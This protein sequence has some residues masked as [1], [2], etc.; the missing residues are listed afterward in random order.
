MSLQALTTAR[1]D[2]LLAELN[3]DPR[4]KPWDVYPRPQLVREGWINLNGTWDYAVSDGPEP[5]RYDRR[6]LVPFPPESSLSG[7][8]EHAPEGSWHC[9]RLRFTLDEIPAGRRLLFHCGGADQLCVLRFNGVGF[10]SRFPLLDGEFVE[11]L[12][13]FREGENE[14]TLAVQDDLRS[15]THPWGK[16]SLRRGGMWYTPVSGV[17]QTVWLEWVPMQ[18]IDSVRITPDLTSA[19][20]EVRVNTGAEVVPAEGFLLFEGRRIPLEGGRAVLTPAEPRLWTP[21]DP[22]LYAFSVLCG[23]DE[24]SSYFALRTIGCGVVGGVPR[25]LLNGKPRFFHGLL[26]QGWWPDGLWTPADPACYDDD[27]LAIK[28]LGFDTVRKHIKVEPELFYHACDRLGVV[29]F[30]DMVNNGKY[31][32]FRDTLLPTLGLQRLPQLLRRRG[33]LEAFTF[34]QHMKVT[35]RRLYNHPSVLYWT[36]FNEGWG[37]RDGTAMYEKLKAL[38]P[39]RVVDT[40][41]GWFR[42]CRTDVDSRHVY[43]RRFRLPRSDKPVVLSEYGGYVWKVPGHSFNPDK[44]YGYRLFSKQE[45]WQAAVE[46]LLREQI[47]PAIP[48]GLC[49]AIYTQLSDVEDETNGLLTYDRRVNKAKN[50]FRIDTEP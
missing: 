21:E 27:L 30:Q 12:T 40:T 4:Y 11:E 48:R 45:D 24:V 29:V 33:A 31:G 42:V 47:A 14:I 35:V 19:A 39:T 6:I 13:G 34:A 22:H 16:Q 26:D 7:V 36:I 44:T 18:W 20:V 23:E 10:G 3:K 49:A 43:F 15:R 1:G 28:A 2:A 25:L 17:W 46:A 37:Q 32:F 38:D 50:A 5:E 8:G 41:S 9:C